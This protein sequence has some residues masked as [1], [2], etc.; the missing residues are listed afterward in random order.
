MRDSFSSVFDSRHSARLDIM[1][2]VRTLVR[3]TWFMLA[4]S[5]PYL[6]TVCVLDSPALLI[7]RAK[8]MKKSEEKS[9]AMQGKL[10]GRV[11]SEADAGMKGTADR[12]RCT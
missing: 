4:L 1:P 8:G 2:G 10:R 6:T 12:D 7:E 11:I 5:F 9:K 3:Q